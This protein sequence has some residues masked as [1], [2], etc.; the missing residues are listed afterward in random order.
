MTTKMT[1]SKAVVKIV[2]ERAGWYC[3]VCGLPASES[4]ALH[5][6]KLRSRGGR[7]TPANLIRVHHGC[8]NLNTDSIHLNP[9]KSENKGWI[10]PGWKEPHEHPFFRPDGSIVLLQDD[11]SVKTLQK[12][13][14]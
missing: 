13:N 5:H 1:I 6:R 8:H 9:E 14:T 4:M 7:D 12:G 2:E 10:V 11:G 3:E